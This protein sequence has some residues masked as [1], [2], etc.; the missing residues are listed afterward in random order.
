MDSERRA[1][2]IFHLLFLRN[3]GARVDKSLFA[4]KGG[5]NLRFFHRS[6]RY[7]EDMD[8]DIRTM[9]TGTLR[10]NVDAVLDG[11][12]FRHALRAQSLLIDSM[13]APKQ[14]ATTQRWKIALRVGEARVPVPTKIEFSRRALDVGLEVAPV[15]AALIRRYRL[16]PVIVQHYGAATAFAQKIAALALRSETQARDIFDLDLLL[17][18]AG[19]AALAE[20]PRNLLRAAIDNAMTIGFDE[21]RGQVV[22]YL[23][24]EYQK[25][26]ADRQSW[27]VLQ[28][29]VVDA[30]RGLL[31]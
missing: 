23:E 31:P 1:I 24:P 18:A 25:D 8:L 3:F 13:S 16:Y 11:D 28:E 7:S 27:E 26:F 30:L 17:G 2:E 9:A 20:D 14:T 4:L 29:R 6:I 10:S 15:E 19:T 5:C 21:F 22:A 12:A